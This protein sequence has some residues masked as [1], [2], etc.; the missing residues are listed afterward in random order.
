M[1]RSTYLCACDFKS[2][3]SLETLEQKLAKLKEN[4][5]N[6]YIESSKRN[7]YTLRCNEKFCGNDYIVAVFLSTIL[8]MKSY[9]TLEFEDDEY[10]R[11]GYLIFH[12][13]PFDAAIKNYQIFVMNYV[14]VIDDILVPE[15]AKQYFK[16]TYNIKNNQKKQKKELSHA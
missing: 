13:N 12:T 15:F 9:T 5:S 4:R 2:P 6:Y 16:K 10:G 1:S 14:P 8:D 7:Y 3:L 11:F